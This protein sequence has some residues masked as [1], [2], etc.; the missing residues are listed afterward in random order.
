M[1]ALF[2]SYYCEYCENNKVNGATLILRRVSSRITGY[3]K[4]VISEDITL[5]LIADKRGSEVDLYWS[6]TKDK[7]GTR[8]LTREEAKQY[9]NKLFREQS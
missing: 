2:T 8:E 7:Q 1:R 6:L 4:W 9:I 5:R 3:A